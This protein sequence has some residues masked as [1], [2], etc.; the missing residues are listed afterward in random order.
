MLVF[1][2]SLRLIWRE[3]VFNK[4]KD[5]CKAKCPAVCFKY[6][7]GALFF[8]FGPLMLAVFL[9]LRNEKSGKSATLA[10]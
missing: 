1:F 4:K 3:G 8:F 9:C 7:S 6:S 5:E 2:L 10:L